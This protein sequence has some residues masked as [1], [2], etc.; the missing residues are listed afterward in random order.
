MEAVEYFSDKVA[1]PDMTDRVQNRFL[2]RQ[3]HEIE[4]L[5]VESSAHDTGILTN[6]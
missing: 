5:L 1:R 6:E 4:E 2:L 3:W